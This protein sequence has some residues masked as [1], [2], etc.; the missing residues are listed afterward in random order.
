M[1]VDIAPGCVWYRKDVFDERKVNID[2][3]VDIEDL[4]AA[5]KKLTFDKDGDGKIDH[6]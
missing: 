6:W 2:K 1:P 3:I 5:G 4:Y